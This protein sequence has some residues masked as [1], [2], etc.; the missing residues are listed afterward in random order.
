MQA[1]QINKYGDNSVLEKAEIPVPKALPHQVVVALKASSVNPVDYKIRSGYLS[2][3]VP[4][5][6]PF[7]L[8][9]EGAGVITEL[10]KDV[11]DFALGDEVIL[12]INFMEGGTY[13]EYV[14]VNADEVLLK[15]KSLEFTD[16]SVIPF[17]L[18]TA[19]TA[20][21][22]D[23]NIK[24]GQKILIHGAGG[25]VGQMAVQIAKSRSLYVM[26]TATGENIRELEE[27][28]IDEIIDYATTDFSTMVKDID[29]V[30]DLVGGETL[31]KSYPVLRKGGFIVSTTQPPNISELDK[32]GLNG[33]MTQTRFNRDKFNELIKWVEEGK[34]KIKKPKVYLFSDAQEAL[35]MIENRQAKSKIVL[36]I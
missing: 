35:S 14:A 3:A 22:D 2:G 10:G 6:F 20:L 13:A 26:G 7:T 12:M 23:A 30:L 25:A 31:A 18:G 11:A 16:A 28:G 34:I 15:P 29:V 21:I 27:L 5:S 8:G 4:K 33:T 36:E 19:Y 17:S 9:W 24:N 1:I 32:F